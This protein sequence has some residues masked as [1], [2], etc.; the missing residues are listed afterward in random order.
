MRTAK[1]EGTTVIHDM[2]VINIA[3]LIGSDNDGSLLAAAT[4]GIAMRDAHKYTHKNKSIEAL[5]AILG[6]GKDGED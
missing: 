5:A 1:N 3:D 6:G 2:S 4:I